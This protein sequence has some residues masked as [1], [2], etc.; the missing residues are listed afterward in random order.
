MD[1][2]L[3]TVREL[4]LTLAAVAGV[5]CLALLLLGEVTGSTLVVFRTGSMAPTMPTGAVAVVQDV[6]ATEVVPGD[7]VTVQRGDGSLPITHRVVATTPDPSVAGGV[8]LVLRGDANASDDP[9]PY[10]VTRVGRVA[11]SAPAVGAWLERV[12]TPP[13]MG[14]LTLGAAALVV[15]TSW[16]RREDARGPVRA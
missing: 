9:A 2:A 5:A 7:V 12:R 8:Q 13:V 14:A 11:W 6:A 3:R 10:A 16:P 15:V 1:R 4:G